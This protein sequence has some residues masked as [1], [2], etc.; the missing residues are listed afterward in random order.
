MREGASN[1]VNRVQDESPGKGLRGLLSSP[2][3]GPTLGEAKPS[4]LDLER[5]LLAGDG[6]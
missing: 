1:D 2:S 4:L 6:V 5:L 3:Q